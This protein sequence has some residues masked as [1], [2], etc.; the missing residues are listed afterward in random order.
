[1]FWVFITLEI[2]LDISK[3]D[4]EIKILEEKKSLDATQEEKITLKEE[5][6]NLTEISNYIEETTKE[7]SKEIIFAEEL[8]YY[9]KAEMMTIDE[10]R[11]KLGIKDSQIL[12]IKLIYARDYFIEGMDELGNKL[13][14]EVENNKEKPSEV[15]ELL[16]EIKRDKILYKNRPD[17]KIRKKEIS[18]NI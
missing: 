15:F 5:Q 11:K 3:K 18:K 13:L 1:M 9:I 17:S 7:S 4:D 6:E 2:K 16:N 10:A 12:L 14:K 8:A